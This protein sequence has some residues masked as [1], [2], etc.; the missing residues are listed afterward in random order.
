MRIRLRQVPQPLQIHVQY[1]NRRIELVV[2]FD[3]HIE[4]GHQ[5]NHREAERFARNGETQISRNRES[6]NRFEQLEESL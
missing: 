6:K 5:T 4:S 1:N 3:R 2:Y